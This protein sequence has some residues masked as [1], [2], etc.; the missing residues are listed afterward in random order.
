VRFAPLQLQSLGFKST[1]YN[2][3]LNSREK[4]QKIAIMDAGQS[5]LL[6]PQ[7]L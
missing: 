5:K 4:R 3:G 6:L 2:G 1:H 7:M